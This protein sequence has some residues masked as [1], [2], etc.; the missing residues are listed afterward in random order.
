LRDDN[1]RTYNTIS[2][3]R[4]YYPLNSLKLNWKNCNEFT[5]K[6][7]TSTRVRIWDQGLNLSDWLCWKLESYR[8][9]IISEINLFNKE[10]V[11]FET[12]NFDRDDGILYR[13]WFILSLS[14]S[15]THIHTHTHA[16]ARA[17]TRTRTRTRTHMYV[18]IYTYL[19]SF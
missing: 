3:K 10:Y 11:L 16:R 9:A 4:Y 7:I 1:F 18:C 6:N 17:R 19:W 15:L 5:A 2:L 13:I 14:L 12:S 8:R